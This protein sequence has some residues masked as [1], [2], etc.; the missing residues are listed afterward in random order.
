MRVFFAASIGFQVPI[1]DFGKGQVI[2]KG[3][4]FTLALTGKLAVGLLVPN[5]NQ[6]KRFTGNHL[7]DVFLTGLSM[8]S[9]MGSFP[10]VFEFNE[11]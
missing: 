11:T 9:P 1:K 10:P 4:V 6:T 5:F 3:I 8:V 7:R 2:W